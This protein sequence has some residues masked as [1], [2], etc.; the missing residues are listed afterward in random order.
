MS[1]DTHL[2]GADAALIDD[3]ELRRLDG[4]LYEREFWAI[5]RHELIGGAAQ[6]FLSLG[7]QQAVARILEPLGQTSLRE[8]AG[9]ADGVKNWEAGPPSDDPETIAFFQDNQNKRNGTWHYVNLPVGTAGYDP[10]Q[11]PMFTRA[12]DVVQMTDIAARVLRGESNRFSEANALR[13]VTHL[14]GD[15][16][17]PIHIGCGYL[18]PSNGSATLVRDPDMAAAHDLPHDRGGNLLFLPIGQRTTL[19]GYWD[20]QL[21]GGGGLVD[22]VAPDAAPAELRDRFVR[23][24]QAIVQRTKANEQLAPVVVAAAPEA[25]VAVW[26]GEALFGARSAYQSLAIIGPHG[27]DSYDVSWEGRDA[28]DARCGPIA[29]EQLTK[30]GNNLAALLNTIWP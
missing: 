18:E 22:G 16:H 11:Y 25:S 23:K 20:S 14:V 12:D 6:G 3:P 7:A 26:A 30:A 19:H 9:W 24:L 15:L 4:S 10:E 1:T 13:L 29:L 8:I 17:Q 2:A 21:G 27:D 28:Y 5:S